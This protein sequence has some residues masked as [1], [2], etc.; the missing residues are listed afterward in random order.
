M[1]T[2]LCLEIWS[3]PI[4]L[5]QTSLVGKKYS[6]FR[7]PRVPLRMR[8][9]NQRQQD[10]READAEEYALASAASDGFGLL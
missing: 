8:D 5:V 10:Q 3:I 2:L 6:P 9:E 1:T 7:S 4:V